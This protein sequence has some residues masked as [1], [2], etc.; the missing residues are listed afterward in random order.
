MSCRDAEPWTHDVPDEGERP[1][2]T[3]TVSQFCRAC[4][5]ELLFEP[6][7]FMRSF[8]GY[9]EGAKETTDG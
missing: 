1:N 2:P 3:G 4:G 6:V 9:A 5:R 8:R 7:G